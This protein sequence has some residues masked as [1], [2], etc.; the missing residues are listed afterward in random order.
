MSA[1]PC[2]LGG[3]T[4]LMPVAPSHFIVLTDTQRRLLVARARRSTG[5]HRD[6]L[7]ARIVLAAADGAGNA[8]IARVLAVNVD[9]VRKWRRR[10]SEHSIDGLAGRV[11]TTV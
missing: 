10:F 5:E 1:P 2:A 8:A 4:V 6:V 11:T 9:T 3:T 7:R